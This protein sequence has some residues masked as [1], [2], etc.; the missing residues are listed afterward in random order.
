MVKVDFTHVMDTLSGP[1]VAILLIAKA[2]DEY[3][4]LAEMQTMRHKVQ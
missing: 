4:E 1:M 3:I 2:N